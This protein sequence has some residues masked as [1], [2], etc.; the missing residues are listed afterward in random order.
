VIVDLKQMERF[1]NGS[2]MCEF[3]SLDI[4]SERVLDLLKPTKLTV[5]KIVIERCTAV[6]F[7][8]DNAGCNGAGCFE[9]KIWAGNDKMIMIKKC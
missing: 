1:E 8:I 3:G 9:V 7:R 2:D 5:W 4:A 6:K